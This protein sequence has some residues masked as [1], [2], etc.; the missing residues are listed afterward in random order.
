MSARLEWSRQKHVLS[1]CY[2]QTDYCHPVLQHLSSKISFRF[3]QAKNSPDWAS[4]RY[5]INIDGLVSG[6]RTV[7][8]FYLPTT[9]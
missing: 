1:E 6:Q 7:L 4:L 8:Q 3:A 5:V 2:H 9:L